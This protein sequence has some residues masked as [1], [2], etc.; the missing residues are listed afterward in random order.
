MCITNGS[1][2]VLQSIALVIP[3]VFGFLPFI[4]LQDLHPVTSI[5]CHSPKERSGRA[6]GLDNPSRMGQDTSVCSRREARHGRHPIADEF[7]S[8]LSPK[9]RHNQPVI[10]KCPS[11][12]T[13]SDH[14][15]SF[16]D[17][18]G[19]YEKSSSSLWRSL[20]SYFE[21]DMTQNSVKSGKQPPLISDPLFIEAT[22]FPPIESIFES[23]VGNKHNELSGLNHQECNPVSPQTFSSPISLLP[24]VACNQTL[25]I[26]PYGLFT[27]EPFPH[28]RQ[29]YSRPFLATQ[30]TSFSFNDVHDVFSLNDVDIIVDEAFREDD[31][32]FLEDNKNPLQTIMIY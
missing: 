23:T 7:S 5:L 20:I 30:V 19:R 8:R 9:S 18:S 11:H 26:T 25:S 12:Q 6:L 27:E 31:Q 24:E 2:S 22:T 3:R 4:R 28:P 10:R 15:S 29:N 1:F 14:P 32:A 21:R 16:D 17:I 13:A